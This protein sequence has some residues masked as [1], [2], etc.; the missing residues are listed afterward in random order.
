LSL[1]GLLL[2]TAARLA[3]RADAERQ[4]GKARTV[5]CCLNIA[6]LHFRD[7]RGGPVSTGGQ[8]KRPPT[9][10]RQMPARSKSWF[11]F[12]GIADPAYA[13]LALPKLLLPMGPSLGLTSGFKCRP[14]TS[15]PGD[16]GQL[17]PA[18]KRVKVNSV[19]SPWEDSDILVGGY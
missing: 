2:K 3:A 18:M 16:N 4:S 11:E 15:V 17:I 10:T 5:A 7:P 9:P 6:H 14:E 13:G 19:T 8:L 12:C 1:E